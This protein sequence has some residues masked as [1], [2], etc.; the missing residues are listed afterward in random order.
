LKY[1]LS[2]ATMLLLHLAAQGH[3]WRGAQGWMASTPH[4]GQLVHDRIESLIFKGLLSAG[5]N[6][7]TL[8]DLGREYV[9]AFPVDELLSQ[10]K[11]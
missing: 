4:S 6:F 5:T 9:A 8:T 2:K 3:V 1:K 7:V 11:R 10:G